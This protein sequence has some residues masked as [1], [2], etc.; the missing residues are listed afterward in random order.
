MTVAVQ[1]H[2]HGELLVEAEHGLEVA[3]LDFLRVLRDRDGKSFFTEHRRGR[4]WCV[5]FAQYSGAVGMPSGRTLEILPK[6]ADLE[7]PVPI[8]RHLMRML[9]ETEQLPAVQGD[10]DQYAASDHLIDAYLRL[11]ADL[12]WSLIRAGAPRDYRREDM[13][14]VHSREVARRETDSTI[15]L[16]YERHEVRH[17]CMQAANPYSRSLASRMYPSSSTRSNRRKKRYRHAHSWSLGDRRPCKSGK[18]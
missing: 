9:R 4:G 15:P 12:A 10:L 2:E 5:G 3:E 7:D 8:R 14:A 17:V 1:V 18:A 16:R 6:I 13:R 11:A